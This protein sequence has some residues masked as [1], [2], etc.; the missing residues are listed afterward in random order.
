MTNA[1]GLISVTAAA[2][3][4]G[5]SGQTIRRLIAAGTLPATRIGTKLL[6]IDPVE[7]ERLAQPST[8][9]AK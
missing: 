3:R 4:L 7:V 8:G 5:V 2:D 9:P 1:Q 6:R